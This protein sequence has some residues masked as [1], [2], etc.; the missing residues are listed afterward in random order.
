MM[1][2]VFQ[3]KP[4]APFSLR[5]KNELYSKNLKMVTYG[6]KS[7]SFLAPNS[8]SI[9]PEEIKNCRPIDPFKKL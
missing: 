4:S 3:I 6:T 7:I 8:C 5:N 9:V 2:E 1:N